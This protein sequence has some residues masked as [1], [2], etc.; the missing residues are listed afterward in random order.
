MA[1]IRL[2][3]WVSPGCVIRI[4]RHLDSEPDFTLAVLGAEDQG[5]SQPSV[6]SG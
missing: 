1:S 6:K 2:G 3:V 5:L 4:L